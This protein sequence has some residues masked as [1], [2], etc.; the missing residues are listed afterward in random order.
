MPDIDEYGLSPLTMRL[1]DFFRL[2]LDQRVRSVDCFF[3]KEGVRI[4]TR[5]W[6]GNA[7]P[8][9]A[10][11]WDFGSSVPQIP[12]VPSR[13]E[14]AEDCRHCNASGESQ[15]WDLETKTMVTV[16]KGCTWCE[17]NGWLIPQLNP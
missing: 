13:P 3:D 17:G 8:P 6:I 2:L 11:F 14:T 16:P 9:V 4:S 7:G 12:V 5:P 10:S 1:T 15:R